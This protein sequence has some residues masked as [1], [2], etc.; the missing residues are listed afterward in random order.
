M[1]ECF[2][3]KSQATGRGERDWVRDR[4]TGLED[5][6]KSRRVV[7]KLRV[8]SQEQREETS[9]TGLPGALP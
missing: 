5:E 9:G 4:N 1:E 7:V 2:L 8:K 6:R 3:E